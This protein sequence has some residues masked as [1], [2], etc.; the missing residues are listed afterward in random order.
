M[1]DEIFRVTNCGTIYGLSS[2]PYSALRPST[3]G[4]CRGYSLSHGQHLFYHDADGTAVTRQLSRRPR[5]HVQSFKS[6]SEGFH[7]NVKDSQQRNEMSVTIIACDEFL[8]EY[9]KAERRVPDNCLVFDC[10]SIRDLVYRVR[11]VWKGGMHD[12]LEKFFAELKIKE[13]GEA[14]EDGEED[15]SEE[16]DSDEGGGN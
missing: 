11:N 15:E 2:L 16:E 4:L 14:K 3:I 12:F 13:T 7:A 6:F 9:I 10:W 8:A 1:S 5:S